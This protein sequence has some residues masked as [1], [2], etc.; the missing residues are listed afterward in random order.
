MLKF[1]QAICVLLL[2]SVLA[3]QVF[4][5]T[6]KTG[7][8]LLVETGDGFHGDEAKAENGEK[9]LGLYVTKRGSSLLTSRVI[10]RRVVDPIVDEEGGPMTRKNVSV[11]QPVE[12]IFLVKG[13]TML[14]PGPVTT[15]YRGGRAETHRLINGYDLASRKTFRLRLGD[16]E[17]QLKV[18]GRKVRYNENPNAEFVNLKLALVLGRQTQILYTPGI[19][20]ETTPWKLLWAGDADGDGKLDLYVG[21]S[22]HYNVSETKLF[23]SSGA[24][25]GQLVKEVAKFV[26]TGC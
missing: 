15:I 18:L 8:V 20:S 24:K 5:Q 10:V 4:V 1:V 17:Y 21:V 23:L 19:V 16:Q 2:L 22:W 9:W 11:D 26:T 3:G 12:P 7:K 14:K 6:A 13:A 25:P